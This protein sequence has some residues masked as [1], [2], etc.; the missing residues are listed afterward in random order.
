MC[1]LDVRDLYGHTG[2]L[3]SIGSA[4]ENAFIQYMALKKVIG[5]FWIGFTAD[6]KNQ[7]L[8][9]EWID[10]WPVYYTNWGPGEPQPRQV[11]VH[12]ANMGVN[13]I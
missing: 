3:V 7:P 12:Y 2:H 10:D 5:S 11:P 9:F 13:G 8:Q 6:G 1:A 4:F